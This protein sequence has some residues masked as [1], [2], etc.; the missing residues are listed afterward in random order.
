MREDSGVSSTRGQA[1]RAAKGDRT[2][3]T[4]LY[5]RLAPALY[6]WAAIRIHPRHRGRLDPLDV[7]QDTWWRALNSFSSFDPERG[8]FRAWIFRIATN[9]LTD[10]YRRLAV[11]G[12]IPS[13]DRVC[14]ET[15]P[16]S[17]AVAQLTSISQAVARDDDVARIISAV[18]ALDA[19]ERTLLA[20]R[21]LEGLGSADTALVLGIGA[22]ACEKRWQR[23][24]AQL[25]ESPIW[26]SFLAMLDED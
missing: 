12:Q 23:L 22:G 18:E 4:R 11:R 9:V 1:E 15:E 13:V 17:E 7:V 3:L 24:R 2:S 10:G 19:D 6:A 26:R 25:R 20:C 8:S 21:G 5:E 16:A 14:R